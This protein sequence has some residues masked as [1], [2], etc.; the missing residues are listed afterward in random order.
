MA[1][2]P[3]N[4]G[5][6]SAT[7]QRNKDMFD[8]LVE[9][10]KV[11]ATAVKSSPDKVVEALSVALAGDNPFA[12]DDDKDKKDDDK[13]DDKSDDEKKESARIAARRERIRRRVAQRKLAD[14]DGVPAGLTDPDKTTTVEGTDTPFSVEEAKAPDATTTVEGDPGGGIT[15]EV[16]TTDTSTT[17][18]PVAS[19]QA[20]EQELLNAADTPTTVNDGGQPASAVTTET[21]TVITPSQD[22]TGPDDTTTVLHSSKDVKARIFD[23]FSFVEEREQIGLSQRNE[24][25]AQISRFEGMTDEQLAGY[26]EA[27]REFAQVAQRQASR[28][29]TVAGRARGD[30]PRLGGRVPDLGRLASTVAGDDDPLDDSLALL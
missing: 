1:Q 26:I 29:V 27:T 5:R 12:K 8:T 21:T 18:L 16:L 25:M 20:G 22:T 30:D 24:R 3:Q 7:A 15:P 11:H 13:K 10:V 19:K 6:L 4:A 2:D 17:T 14:G 23:I 28:R 9:G